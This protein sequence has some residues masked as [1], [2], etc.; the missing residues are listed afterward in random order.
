MS[1]VLLGP[2]AHPVLCLALGVSGQPV[3]LSGHLTG[4]AQAGIDRGAWPALIPGEGDLTGLRVTPD[5]RLQRYAA[6][7]GLEPKA[8]EGE[9]VLGIGGPPGAPWDAAAWDAALAAEIARQILDAP[10]DAE[11]AHLAWR[12]PMIGIWA[13]SRVRAGAS[14]RSGGNIVAAREPGDVQVH[15]RRQIASG[16]FATDELVLSHRRHDGGM[17]YRMTR[18]GFLMGDAVVLLPWDPVRDRVLVIE[19]FR[20]A[21]FLRGD[22]QPWLLEPVAGRVDAGESVEDAARREAQEEAALS[23]SR[24][25]HAFDAY[26]SPGAVC[27]FLYQF[28]GIAD[29]P[30]GVEGVHGLDGEAEDIRGHLLGRS[31]L[32]GMVLTGQI[33]NGPLASLAL[34]LEL[35]APRL[36]AELAHAATG[37]PAA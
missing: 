10:A 11:P 32:T 7:M 9:T 34:W 19:Q 8:I 29:L 3:R 18:E 33:T 22:P 36:R 25:F 15:E 2:L 27:E 30:D 17:T 14:P 37:C 4:G 24:L 1:V 28:V 13:A 12:L 6:V 21:P 35:S 20:P 23:V 31:D 5:P 16:F 26:P